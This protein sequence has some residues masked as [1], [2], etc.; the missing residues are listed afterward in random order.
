MD[1]LSITAVNR[2]DAEDLL[3]FEVQNRA[4]FESQINARNPDYYSLQGV[5]EAI[6]AVI[7]DAFDDKGYQYL[8]RE[9]SGHLV[10]R[11][12]LRAV[13]RAH[14]YSAVLGYRIAQHKTGKGYATEAVRLVLDLAFGRLNLKRIE[15]DARSDNAALLAVLRRNGFVQN[16]HSRKSFELNGEWFDRFHF[17]RHALG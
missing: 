16:G 1:R 3:Q 8:L 12:N 6:E 10:G 14:Y 2:A 7:D 4:Y 17:E 11:V 5:S 9:P 15:A 13:Q